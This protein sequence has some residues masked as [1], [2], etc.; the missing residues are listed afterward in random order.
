MNRKAVD[1]ITGNYAE[2]QI[3][4]K[5]PINHILDSDKAFCYNWKKLHLEEY[6]FFP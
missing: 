4:Q 3:N 2:E 6:I 5:K 1:K